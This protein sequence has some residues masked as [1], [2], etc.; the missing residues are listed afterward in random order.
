M[1]VDDKTILEYLIETN[2]LLIQQTDFLN[3]I[4][5]KQT[6]QELRL[7]KMEKILHDRDTKEETP[8]TKTSLV[9]LLNKLKQSNEVNPPEET[10]ET[11][12]QSPILDF[13]NKM[14]QFA[15][16]NTDDPDSEKSVKPE[17]VCL[18]FDNLK[19]GL[20]ESFFDNLKTGVAASCN[21]NPDA[22]NIGK[23]L[24]DLETIRF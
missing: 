12:K 22:I 17:D 21:V 6:D 15:K 5:K 14:N 11:E 3:K 2:E 19:N 20:T 23:L 24:S 4:N 9:D 10:P 13:L 7:C 18:Y 16:I 8:Q 1:Q